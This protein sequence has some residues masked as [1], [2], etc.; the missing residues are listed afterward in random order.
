MAGLALGLTYTMVLNLFSATLV[1]AAE[2]HRLA[3]GV[4]DLGAATRKYV[5]MMG[6]A[7]LGALALGNA[8]FFPMIRW[9]VGLT[10]RATSAP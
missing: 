1:E 7:G 5:A 6:R 8:I 2:W 4:G 9:A 10:D 3:H